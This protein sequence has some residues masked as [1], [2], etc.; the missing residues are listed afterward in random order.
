MFA[1]LLQAPAQTTN[2]MIAGYTVIFS[3]IL[4][5]ILSL[6]LRTRKLERELLLLTELEE[7][8][9][10]PRATTQESY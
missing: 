8:E 3:V 7:K 6:V 9:N 1:T 5:Y 4:L 2:Y 10:E